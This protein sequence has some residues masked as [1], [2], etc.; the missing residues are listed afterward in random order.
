MDLSPDD[1]LLLVEYY[2]EVLAKLRSL[3]MYEE[4]KLSGSTFDELWWEIEGYEQLYEQEV[5]RREPWEN[6]AWAIAE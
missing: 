1:Y 3:H 5:K 4:I 6:F 2:N